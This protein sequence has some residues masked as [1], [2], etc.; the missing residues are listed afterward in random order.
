M[1]YEWDA[2]KARRAKLVRAALACIAATLVAGVPLSF[3]MHA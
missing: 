2:R 1:A 3:L